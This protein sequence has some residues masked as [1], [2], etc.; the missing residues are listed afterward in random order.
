M[1]EGEVFGTV[2]VEAGKLAEFAR[3]AA[4]RGAGLFRPGARSEIV[5]VEGANQLAIDIAKLDVRVADGL[6]RVMIPVRSDQ[7]GSV[8]IEVLFAVGSANEPACLYA[9]ASKKPSGPELIVDAWARRSS[10]LRGSVCRHGHRRRYGKDVRGNLLVPVELI[11]DGR[12]VAIVPMA[13][14]RFAGS[15]TLK[16]A[17][18]R[19]ANEGLTPMAVGKSDLGI[20]GDL[21][22][23]LGIF[24]LAAARTLIGSAIRASLKAMCESAQPRRS[25]R[26]RCRAGR[27]RPQHR[28][29]RYVVPLVDIEDP[30]LGFA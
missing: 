12:G 13:R 29:R 30:P 19:G 1:R 23:A 22:V 27:C 26:C 4:R 17:A 5:W 16:P 20:L 28:S 11:A 10:R 21:A 15:S 2:F 7:T 24:T 6:I 25:S 14:H 3:V 9:A 18:A 8:P